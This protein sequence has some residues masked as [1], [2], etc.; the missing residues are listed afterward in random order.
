ME[1][2]VH[3]ALGAVV[4]WIEYQLLPNSVVTH[5]SESRTTIPCLDISKENA[6][7]L[8]DMIADGITPKVKIWAAVDLDFQDTG[9]NVVGYIPSA[10]YGTPADRFVIAAD[11]YDKWWYGS[12]DNGAG[13]ARLLGMA[14]ALVASHYT[15]SRTIIFLATSAE[16]FGWA[17][18]EFDWALGA[19]WEIFVIHPEW[20]G[21]SLGMFQL[22]GGGTIGATSVS[23]FGTPETLEWRKSLL[24]KFNEWFS[25]TAP[26]SKYYVKASAETES[27]ATTWADGFSFCAAGVPMMS[28]SSTRSDYAGYDYH[29]QKDAMYGIS[30]ESLAMSTIANGLAIIELDR[31]KFAPYSFQDRAADLKAALD[32]K[33]I[34][35]AGV[36]TKPVLNALAKFSAAGGDV[37]SL[38]ARSSASAVKVAKANDLL[39]KAAYRVLFDMTTV[40]EYTES[41]YS[42]ITYMDDALFFREGISALQ[43][44]NIDGALMWL[45]NPNGMYTGRMVSPEVYQYL[46]IDRWDNPDRTDLFWATGRLAYVEDFYSEYQSLV[47]KKAAGITDYSDEIAALTLHYQSVVGHLQE[48]LDSMVATLDTATA[49]LLDAESLMA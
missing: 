17:D 46:V 21:K 8:K 49:L 44:G 32:T 30:A 40:G 6:A 5:D 15:P 33:L 36:V 19:W 9:Y 3:G 45:S 29:T 22:E 18:T 43:T 10:N 14:K 41:M 47:E 13:V 1:A 12:D 25:K 48:S 23:S 27:F 31:A 34:G 28:V 39:L 26:W 16:E 24:P 37:W 11:H 38:M 20:V 2:E 35:A 42:H 7:V 4:T